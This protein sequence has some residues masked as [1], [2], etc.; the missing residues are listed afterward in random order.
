MVTGTV[1]L[2]PFTEADLWMCER[3]AVDPDFGGEF[4]WTGFGW[5]AAD[6][7]RWEEDGLLGS[8]PYNLVV[9]SEAAAV[10][11]VNWRDTDRAGPTVWEIGILIAPEHRGRGIGTE[12]QRLLVDHLF[13]TTPT[14]R[15][16]AGTEVENTAEQ[17]ALERCGF[18]REGLLRSNHFRAGQWRDAYVYGLLRSDPR[19]GQPGQNR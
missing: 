14:V 8:S 16:W 3:F 1:R 7:K 19:P 9:E 12:A 10:G 18:Q 17:N 2:R 6:R 13:A 4:E 15:I 11:W 5:P